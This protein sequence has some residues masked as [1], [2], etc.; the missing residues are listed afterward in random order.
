MTDRVIGYLEKYIEKQ[1]MHICIRIICMNGVT[2]KNKDKDIRYIFY[3]TRNI[4][5]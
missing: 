2:Y 3:G 4:F 1:E 5:Y